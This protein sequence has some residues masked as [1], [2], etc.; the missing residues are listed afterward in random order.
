MAERLAFYLDEHIPD[1]VA[2]ALRLRGFEVLTTHEAGMLGASD[3]VQLEFARTRGR[4]LFTQDA[5]YIALHRDGVHHAGI[6]YVQ[7]HTALR[8][9]IRQILLLGEVAMPADM[10]NRLEYL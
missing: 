8:Y 10:I 6:A 2:D 1:S 5:D 3:P 9:M 7:Q 4:V